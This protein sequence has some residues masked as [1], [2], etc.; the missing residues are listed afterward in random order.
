MPLKIG[1]EHKAVVSILGDINTLKE[2][3]DEIISPNSSKK[4]K[5][6]DS[7]RDLYPFDYDL[8]NED[9]SR[10]VKTK[11]SDTKTKEVSA[12]KVYQT[13]SDKLFMVN[14][15]KVFLKQNMLQDYNLYYTLLDSYQFFAY[16][17]LEMCDLLI[18]DQQKIIYLTT[19]SDES[20]RIYGNLE[21]KIDEISDVHVHLGAVLDFHYRINDILLHPTFQSF[22]KLPSG[23]MFRVQSPVSFFKS[24]FG[25]F[26]LLESILVTH[27]LFQKKENEAILGI[28]KSIS[29]LLKNQRH[30]QIEQTLNRYENKYKSIRAGVSYETYDMPKNSMWPNSLLHQSL[31]HFSRQSDPDVKS[32]DKLLALFFL[33]SLRSTTLKTNKSIDIVNTAIR[34]YLMLRNITKTILVQQHKR[35][36][37]G[38][39]WEY[40]SSSFKKRK[41]GYSEKDLLNSVIHP[42]IKTN[43]EGRICV[44]D[45]ALKTR[46]KIIRN[47][48][49]LKL[50]NQKQ[51]KSE[52][53]IKFIYHFMK[54]NERE[55]YKEKSKI[56]KYI[57]KHAELREKIKQQAKIINELLTDEKLRFYTPS[58]N[59]LCQRLANNEK[60]SEEEKEIDLFKEHIQGIDAANKEYNA[61]PEVFAPVFNFFKKS[62]ST[63]GMALVELSCEVKCKLETNLQY[64]FHAGEEFR[65]IVSGV[66]SIFEAVIFLGLTDEDRIGHGVALGIKPSVFL[67]DRRQILLPQGEYFDNLVFMYYIFSQVVN[68]PIPLELLKSKIMHLFRRIYG[69]EIDVVAIDDLIDA[70]LLRRNCPNEIQRVYMKALEPKKTDV[71]KSKSYFLK[72]L[73]KNQLKCLLADFDAYDQIYIKSAMPDFFNNID[74]SLQPQKR[75]VAAAKNLKAFE[76]LDMYYEIKEK[77]DEFFDEEVIFDNDVYEYLQD[78]ILEKIIAKKNIFIEVL[79][80]SN[81]LITSIGSYEAHPFIRLNPPQEILPNKFGIRTKKVK[82]LLGTDDPGIQGTNIIMELYHI[83]QLV[84]KKYGNDVAEKYVLDIVKQG[85]YVFNKT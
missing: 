31:M 63:S 82:I 4:N 19:Y 12:I 53:M 69:Y 26:S 41:D 83:K 18:N 49:A 73:D 20:F 56:D 37:F 24:F 27:F 42:T 15:G 6:Q 58:K 61:N 30:T 64:T 28:L 7:L 57:V 81:V 2:V 75:Y 10:I 85:N 47:I 65:D 35:A 71:Y 68:P 50:I 1:V 67:N 40:S 23:L 25:L 72:K 52:H 38:Y 46:E 3:I 59:D 78:Y 43:I 22:E 77:E 80:T 84:A 33:E 66:R 11:Y 79:P 13:I 34:V 54:P 17:L 74:I 60:E 16:Y 39:F 44:G 51:P 14:N 32:A 21:N 70:W 48:D 55:D 76:L 45:T 8:E 5:I 62:I 36:G 29:W 9:A